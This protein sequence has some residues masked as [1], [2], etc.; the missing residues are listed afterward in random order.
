[1]Y[2]LVAK[3]DV[4]PETCVSQGM[5]LADRASR[6]WKIFIDDG[7][8]CVVLSIRLHFPPQGH[9]SPLYSA[10]LTISATGCLLTTSL[11]ISLAV[12]TS[13]GSP[14]PLL[15]VSEASFSSACLSTKYTNLL[16]FTLSGKAH[17]QMG[18]DAMQ[19]ISVASGN[20]A[21]WVIGPVPA[22]Q[23]RHRWKVNSVPTLS[24]ANQK[25]LWSWITGQ[26]IPSS[27]LICS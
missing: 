6:D 17:I 7:L 18:Q 23:L 11:P 10:S 19:V 21:N 13:T 2:C 3:H 15:R 27:C 25:P 26:P 22:Q 24:P 1:M 8:F 4:G 9:T 5:I 12:S 14:P 16:I 20:I